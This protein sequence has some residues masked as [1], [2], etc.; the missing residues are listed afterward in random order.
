MFTSKLTSKQ[1][2]IAVAGLLAV[3][4][5][6]LGIYFVWH[7]QLTKQNHANARTVQKE[8]VLTIDSFEQKNNQELT[9][10]SDEEVLAWLAIN[11]DGNV[12][13]YFPH[14]VA[15][16]VIPYSIDLSEVADL[17]YVEKSILAKWQKQT[18]L[19]EWGTYKD[20]TGKK[21][22]VVY[23][24]RPVKDSENAVKAYLLVSYSFEDVVKNLRNKS[25]DLSALS[26]EQNINGDE[27][28]IFS[29]KNEGEV[30]KSLTENKLHNVNWLL[31]LSPKATIVPDLF[32]YIVGIMWALIIMAMA[33]FFIIQ[34]RKVQ[35][36]SRVTQRLPSV[37]G[38]NVKVKDANKISLSD[39]LSDNVVTSSQAKAEE[40]NLSQV[41]GNQSMTYQ[42]VALNPE[43]FRAYDIRGVVGVDLSEDAAFT[44]GQAIGAEAAARGETTVVVGYD[45]RLSGPSLSAALIAGLRASGRD[46]INVGMVPT[47]VLYFA[48][49]TIATGSGVMLTGSHNPANYNGF[50]IMVAG[51]TLSGDAIQDL[52]RRIQQQDFVSGNG[53]LTAQN[54]ADSYVERIANDVVVGQPLKIVV[55]AGNGVAGPIA[56]KVFQALGCVVVPLFCEVDGNFPNHHP[57]PSKPKNLQDLIR[58]VAEEKADIGIAFDGDGDRIGVVT[59]KGKNI[60]PDRLMMLYAENVLAANPGADIVFDVKCTRDLATLISRLGGRPVMSKTGHSFIKSKLKETGAALAGEMSGHIF[61]NDRWYGFDDATYSA[62]R[63]LEILANED[64]NAD[65]VFARYP[66]NPST[67]EINVTVADD[68]KFAL[69]ELLKQ[70][71]QFPDAHTITIDGLRVEFKEG[72]G[73]I[74]ASNTTPCLV[75]RFEGQ[76]EAGLHA[77]QEKFRALL[78][79]VDP[80]L[81]KAW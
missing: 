8:L 40:F 59:P 27:V 12:T 41:E 76:T 66:E 74:R 72:W 31:M 28:F 47:P 46:V 14:A 56:L 55:D 1:L 5:I 9:S 4:I 17:S 42:S 52:L 26:L 73:L 57:D 79:Q 44:I 32:G 37:K 23:F 45:G 20:V 63:L 36:F 51:D 75:I 54:V 80:E 16:R 29:Q 68:K 24:S 13:S 38:S 70:K 67:P 7:K 60:Y 48:A 62:S 61:F 53:A 65:Q 19:P 35:D 22:S 71:A 34:R 18:V 81:A 78:A 33:V 77:V 10:V 25:M 58:V 43:I 49:K 69:V 3:V 21:I 2:F 30:F 6:Q 39:R 15:A 64:V 11:A 50:K